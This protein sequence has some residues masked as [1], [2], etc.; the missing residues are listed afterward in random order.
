LQTGWRSSDGVQIARV[1]GDGELHKRGGRSEED[2]DQVGLLEEIHG[3]AGMDGLEKGRKPG[4][5]GSVR[6]GSKQ[7]AKAM[8]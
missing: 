2:G 4:E 5:R 3:K 7:G 8:G 6:A 1:G